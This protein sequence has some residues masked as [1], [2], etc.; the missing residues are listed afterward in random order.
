MMHG[1]AVDLASLRKPE[2]DLPQP[3]VKHTSRN[4]KDHLIEFGQP[5]DLLSRTMSSSF[6]SLPYRAADRRSCSGIGCHKTS[7][8][9]IGREDAS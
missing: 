4:R 8:R 9:T 3:L 5:N 7:G 2:V 6:R 1:K